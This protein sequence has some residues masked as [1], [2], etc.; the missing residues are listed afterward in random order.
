MCSSLFTCLVS[1]KRSHLLEEADLL[2]Y[3]GRDVLFTLRTA[4]EWHP[5]V[6]R[7]KLK[8]LVHVWESVL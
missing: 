6:R 5:Q 8:S 4:L 2:S 7:F 3:R 1:T